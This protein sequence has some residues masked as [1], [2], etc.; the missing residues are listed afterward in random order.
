MSRPRSFLVIRWGRL[1]DLVLAAAATRELRSAFPEAAIHFAVKEELAGM[2]ELLPGVDRVLPFGGGGAGA[3]LRYA[4]SLPERR[5]DRVVDLQG[6]TRS[7]WLA[8]LTGPGRTVRYPRLTMRRRALV[9][10]K[11]GKGEH[12]RPVWD[13]YLDAVERLGTA[14]R[15][16][17]PRLLPVE[18]KG[19]PGAVLFAPGAGRATKR[20]PAERFAET[21]RRIGRESGRP[22]LLLGSEGEKPLLERVAAGAGGGARVLAGIPFRSTVAH[23]RDGALLITND[24]GPMHVAGAVGTPVIAL[25]GP[26]VP[27]LGFGPA[28]EK[29]VVLSLDLECRPC[30]LHGGDRCPLPDRSHTC[31]T[32]L[33]ADR[34]VEAANRILADAPPADG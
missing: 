26:T 19:T 25:F 11:R 17:P 29:D 34:V 8:L 30:S 15:R 20:W 18:E 21:A 23:L 5:Y 33:D 2:A 13:R 32:G 3:L 1:G 24:S 12:S 10:W 6:N 4:R 27:E 7:R 31:M 22:I 9:R 16:D 14:V 28:G